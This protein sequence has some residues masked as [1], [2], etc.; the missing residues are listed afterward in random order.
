MRTTQRAL[1]GLLVLILMHFTICSL[2]SINGGSK[3]DLIGRC[4]PRKL[5]ASVSSFST[6][7]DK[8]KISYEAPQK[9]GT[10]SLRKAPPSN[11]NPTQN[12]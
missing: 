5:L 8:L 2:V 6:S 1:V 3:S 9:S 12:K 11:S 4:P 10:T 7:L